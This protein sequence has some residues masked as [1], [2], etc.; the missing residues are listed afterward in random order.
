MRRALL[1][2]DDAAIREIGKISLE[3]IGGWS[4][5]AVP[6]GRA[7]LEAV[8]A[9]PPFDALLLDVMMPGLDGPQTL[10]LLR[11]QQLIDSTTPAVFLTA[12]LQPA[13]RERLHGAGA[14]GV[15]AKPFDPTALASELEAILEACGDEA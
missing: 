3:R 4:V 8:A 12:K 5:T 11:E 9:A 13:D 15:I 6:S 7:A 1:V 2:D 10:A 14:A